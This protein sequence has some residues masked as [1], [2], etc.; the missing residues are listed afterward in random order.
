[1]NKLLL[2]LQSCQSPS[3]KHRG[4]GRYSLAL[5]RALI[6]LAPVYD[7]QIHALVSTALDG[8]QL[9]REEFPNL[10]ASHWHL[11]D[12][13]PGSQFATAPL[14]TLHTVRLQA[15]RQ[16]R[17]AVESIQPHALHVHSVFEGFNSDV[18]A[19]LHA[20]WPWV[21]GATVYDFIPYYLSSTY[22]SYPPIRAWYHDRLRLMRTFD[23]HAAISE[24]AQTEARDVLRVDGPR[25]VNLR[26][27]ADPQFVPA[28]AEQ[29]NAVLARLGVPAE[30]ILYTGGIDPRKNLDRL[31]TAY[32]MLAPSIRERFPLVIVCAVKPNEAELLHAQAARVG[33]APAQLL[34][35]GYVSDQ[36]LVALYSRC[37]VFVFPSIHEGFGLPVLEAMRCGA[38]VVGSWTSSVPEVLG[39][40]EAGFDPYS[41]TAIAQ[42]LE[43]ALFDEAFRDRF[44]VHAR[45]HV[46]Q[47]SWHQSAHTLLRA[48]RAALDQP[49]GR[50]RWVPLRDAPRQSAPL[51]K[52]ILALVSPWPPATSGIADYVARWLPWLHSVY[53][54]RL[55]ASEDVTRASMNHAGDSASPAPVSVDLA[56]LPLW[57]P[58]TLRQARK[59]DPALP[60]LYHVGNSDHHVWILELMQDCPGVVVLH[61]AYLGGLVWSMSAA[62]PLAQRLDA[63]RA[64]LERAHGPEAAADLKRDG[65]DAVLSRW[66]MSA[67][68]LAGQSRVLVHS[69]HARQLFQQQ[70]QVEP[71]ARTA[72]AQEPAPCSVQAFVPE[73]QQV[74]FLAPQPVCWS[75]LQPARGR[76][77]LWGHERIVVVPGHVAAT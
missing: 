50:R 1:M 38:V 27:D 28:H 61:D 74:P 73:V 53:D 24:S 60:I 48:Y 32:S 6:E 64:Q 41:T 30:F 29:S 33:L 62:L 70:P 51:A 31:I 49:S 34:L 40:A 77:G 9:L 25:L 2:D 11:V 56:A 21:C 19:S 12:L 7:M 35:T 4:I 66:P 63:L 72:D 5:S 59:S 68:V 16:Y 3:S 57:S 13:P 45:N 52:P 10:E 54:L 44:L 8:A 20:D 43:R 37:R 76:L 58:D 75:A 55:V 42:A 39:L 47:F 15:E 46:Q 71:A 22:L 14:H 36:D 69:A 67:A 23:L 26:A 17:A 18:V 65:L